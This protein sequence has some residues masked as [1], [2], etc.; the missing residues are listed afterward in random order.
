MYITTELIG[1]I[2]EVLIIRLFIQGI[3]TEKNKIIWFQILAYFLYG[4]GLCVLSFI[5]NASFARIFFCGVGIIILCLFLYEAKISQAIYVGVTF[6][7]L[8]ALIDVA[9]FL[10]LPFL[11]L[12]SQA[13]MSHST[14]RCVYIITTHITLLA[15]IVILLLITR[16]KRTA[17]TLPFVLML[18]PGCIISIVL[19][20]AFCQIVQTTGED[21]PI[22][23][24]MAAIGLLYMNI[25]LVF[26]AEQSKISAD[27]KHDV[28][29]AEQHYIMQEQYYEQL[30]SEQNETRAMFH[31]I[32]KYMLAMRTMVAERNSADASSVLEEAQ[33]LF[34]NLGNVVDVGNAVV[35]IIL[36][37]YKGRIEEAGIEF[38][39]SVSIPETISV[40]PVDLYILL[41]NAFDNAIEACLCLS[42]NDRYIKLQIKQHKNLLYLEIKNP[43]KNGYT[44]RKKGKN[45]GYG[46]QNMRRCLA[47]Y[48]GQM[49]T[50]AEDNVF[51]LC[52]CLND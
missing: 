3:L 11:E 21:L 23:F 4:A 26:Y 25:L 47:K 44:N 22:P 12:D 48:D 37:E 7:S 33:T 19:G 20:C 38:D 27:R 45:H 6:C 5:P 41:G 14:S 13:I 40:A 30:R 50:F 35:S 49:S 9:L 34:D 24:L 17:I 36:N 39:F 1:V 18:C 31:D 28:E 46:L 2:S 16:R 10:L 51:S 32:K 15:I 52:I 29:L 8:Y 43:F 42:E